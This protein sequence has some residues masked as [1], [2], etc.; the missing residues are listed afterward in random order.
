MVQNSASFKRGAEIVRQEVFGHVPQLNVGSG[1]KTAKKQ[2][3]GTYLARYY[4]ES[5]N[6]YAR[7]VSSAQ[8][9]DTGNPAGLLTVDALLDPNRFMT[10][11]KQR[12]KNTEG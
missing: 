12:R 3:T 1:G 7:M 9:I 6:K 5:I 10:T 2:L 4:P 8:I 11:G